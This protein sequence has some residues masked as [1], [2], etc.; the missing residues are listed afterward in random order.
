MTPAGEFA[1]FPTATEESAP[2]GIAGR[3]DGKLWFTEASYFVREV[4]TIATDGTFGTSFRVHLGIP[5]GPITF[6]PEAT[7]GVAPSKALLVRLTPANQETLFG[8]RISVVTGPE[9]TSGRAPT[10]S[11]STASSGRARHRRHEGRGDRA[12]KSVH[13]RLDCGGSARGC[14]GR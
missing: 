14:A 11:R 9:G 10:G 1:L 8:R 5:Q 4:G 13:L 12:R 2:G 6:G 7:R 3:T